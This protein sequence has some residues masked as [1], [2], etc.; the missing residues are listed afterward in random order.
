M[1]I[2]REIRAA[3]ETQ[4]TNT[5]G[6][7]T[8]AFENVSFDPTTEVS[9]ITTSF[10]PTVRRPTV[11]GLNPIQ[12]YQGLFA[13]TVFCKEGD[14]PATADEL[15]EKVIAAFE[16]TTDLQFTNSENETIT[17]SIDYAERRQGLL[18]SPWYYIPISIGW[19][20]YK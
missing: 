14:G 13:V 2:H 9:F 8:I 6:L 16:A 18:E 11:R 4:L 17:V 15:A 5:S 10:I 19:Y 1:T 12:R 7:P 20:S 3:L